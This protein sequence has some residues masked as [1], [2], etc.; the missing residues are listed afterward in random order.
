MKHKKKS[1]EDG[2][3]ILI[4]KTLGTTLFLL[5]WGMVAY[6]GLF[7][8]NLIIEA[9]ACALWCYVGIVWRDY[10]L[11]AMNGIVGCFAFIGYFTN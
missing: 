5:S 6:G 7:P 4:I 8:Y 3:A 9:I 2:T 10:N 1:I 11:I